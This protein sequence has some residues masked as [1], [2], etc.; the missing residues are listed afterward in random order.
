MFYSLKTKLSKNWWI[1]ECESESAS[2]SVVSNSL[3]PH[4]VHGILQARIL[5]WVAFPFSRG[6][7]QPRDRTQVSR[8]AGGFFTK[9]SHKGSPR[10]GVG[11]LSFLQR[12]FPTQESNW[13]LLHCRGILYQAS[14]KGSPRILEWVAY[15]FSSESSRPRNQTGVS[16]TA[17][18]FFTNWD[19]KNTENVSGE[20]HLILTQIK[21]AYS[22]M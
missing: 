14:H 7:S 20:S 17:G 2:R 1:Y 6:F 4:V 3:C 19:I 22:Y 12:I 10:S 21:F 18:G 15:S 16:C 5:E 11:S 9:L 13:S 8:I